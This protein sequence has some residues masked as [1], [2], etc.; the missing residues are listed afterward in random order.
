MRPTLPRNVAIQALSSQLES[1]CERAVQLEGQ[2]KSELAAVHPEYADSAGNLLHYMALRHDD[3]RGLQ[4]QLAQLGLSSLGSAEQH[5]LASVRSVQKALQSISGQQ[6]HD[7][8]TGRQIFEQSKDRA[9]KHTRDLLGANTDGRGVDIMVTLPLEAADDYQ[10]VHDLIVTGMD[11]ARINC[12][13]DTSSDWLKM[14]E[15]IRRASEKSGKTCKI[16]MDLAGPKLRTGNLVP[17]PGV[18]RIRPRRDALGRV[19][20]PGRVRFVADDG[21][22]SGKKVAVVPVPRKC[23]EY[24]D[25]GDEFRFKDTRGRKRKLNVIEKDSKGLILES[26]KRAYIATG[27]KLRL[28]RKESG[29][30]IKFRVGKLRPIE[31]PII[32]RVGDTLVLERGNAPGEPACV[33]RDELVLEPAHVTCRP[34]EIFQRISVGAPVRLNDGKIEAFVKTVSPDALTIEITGARASGSRL[35][36][37]RSINFPGSEIPCQGLTDDDRENLAFIVEHADAVCLSFVRKPDDI[38]ALQ[39]ELQK[40]PNCRLGIILKIETKQAFKDLPRILLAAMQ[41]YPAGIMIA[42]GDLAVEVGWERLAELQEEILW[43]CEAARLPVIWAT[44]VL[45]GAA[46]KGRPTRAEITDAAMSQRADCVMLNKGPHILGAIK[47]LDNILR[48][49]QGHQYKKTARLRKLS[50]TEF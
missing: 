15:N 28:G 48:R 1:V 45:E 41:A 7:L 42:R 19:V 11:I 34:S 44:Q 25:V 20:S 26:H 21:A 23:I 13:H 31:L 18:L 47:M 14:V 3:I 33:D 39:E 6:T 10:L 27:T 9:E 5:V 2:F 37:D 38:N 24:A 17:G 43:L 46:K 35:R 36:S 40:Y 22:W 49:M 4:D 50:V 32:L 12:A 30:K 16:V 8:K 29:E